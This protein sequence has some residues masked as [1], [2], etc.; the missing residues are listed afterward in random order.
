MCTFLLFVVPAMIIRATCR[1]VWRLFYGKKA[2]EQQAQEPQEQKEPKVETDQERK[3]REREQRG[4]CPYEAFLALFGY[5]TRVRKAVPAAKVVRAK[6]V[7]VK[8]ND[9]DDSTNKVK[10]Y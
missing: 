4:F 8:A 2:R 9:S 7:N 10:A 5:G 3:V 1:W 6:T